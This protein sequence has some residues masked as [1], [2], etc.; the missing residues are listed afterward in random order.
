ME[1]FVSNVSNH[2]QNQK[3]YYTDTEQLLRITLRI[4]QHILSP[5]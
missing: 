3:G 1:I 2:K 5:Y 4:I